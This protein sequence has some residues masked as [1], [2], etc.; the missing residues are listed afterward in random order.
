MPPSSTSAARR[1]ASGASPPRTFSAA[2]ISTVWRSSSSSSRST[3]LRRVKFRMS[4]ATRARIAMVHALGFE[5]LADRKGDAIPLLGGFTELPLPGFRQLV[6]LGAAVV[7]RRFPFGREPARF[8]E[9]VQRRKERSGLDGKRSAGH[10]LD[11]ARHPE[12]V[13]LAG[14][15]RLEDEQI[16]CAL[17]KT[18]ALGHRRL[19]L[20]S[21]GYTS[22]SLAS[23]LS[24]VNRSVRRAPHA[25]PYL[26]AGP[27]RNSSLSAPGL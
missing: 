20:V 17:Q 12:P 22:G 14:R 26:R 11:A 10:L 5:C 15:E 8:L 7:L 13:Q 2:R 4:L 23:F 25:S 9:P 21:N 16:E 3:R 27:P 1:A 19:P 6:V 24:N 18:R